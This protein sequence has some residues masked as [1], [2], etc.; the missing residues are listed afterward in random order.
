M[1]IGIVMKKI[2]IYIQ[3]IIFL[4]FAPHNLQSQDQTDQPVKVTPKQALDAKKEQF[5][6]VQQIASPLFDPVTSS[7][8]TKPNPFPTQS[9]NEDAVQN[10]FSAMGV[11]GEL[12]DHI[13]ICYFY[14]EFITKLELAAHTIALARTKNID[15]LTILESTSWQGLINKLG[16]WDAVVK[17]ID[18]SQ[19]PSQTDINTIRGT[20]Q[21]P[22]WKDVINTNFWKSINTTPDLIIKSNF[23]QNYCK[24]TVAQDFDKDAS[25]LGSIYNVETRIFMYIPNIDVAYYNEDFTALRLSSEYFRLTMVLTDAM[26]NRLIKQ[27]FDWK[28]FYDKTTNNIDLLKSYSAA[29]DFKNTT[30]YKLANLANQDFSKVVQ[31]AG[32]NEFPL[33]EIYGDNKPN[34]LAVE[35]ITCLAMI[36]NLQAQLLNLFNT[37]NLETTMKT[38]ADQTTKKPIPNILLYEADDHL[39]LEDLAMVEDAFAQ[40]AETPEEVL[41]ESDEP[42]VVQ[43]IGSWMSNNWHKV[44][45]RAKH[46]WSNVEQAGKATWKDIKNVGGDLKSLGEDALKAAEDEGGVLSQTMAAFGALVSVV[47]EGKDPKEAAKK[48]QKLWQ[49]AVKLQQKVAVD[50]QKANKDLQ[51]VMND[52]EVV[53]RDAS[54]IGAQAIGDVIGLVDKKLGEDVAGGLTAAAALL[55]DFYANLVDPVIAVVGGLVVLTADAAAVAANVVTK[56]IIDIA[57]GNFSQLGSDVLDGIETMVAD[58]AAT[59]WS[60]IS[61]IGK[62][63]LQQLSDAVKFIG[64]M[65]AFLTD[66]LV[67]TFAFATRTLA[68]LADSVGLPGEKFLE[69]MA[70]EAEAH[71]R[72]IAATITTVLLVVAVIATD[73]AAIPLLAMTV[74]P[75][76]FQIGGAFQQ[77]QQ[78]EQMKQEQKQFLDDYKKFVDNNE[79]VSTNAKN[80]WALELNKKYQAQITNQERELGFYQN[81][82]TSYFEGTQDQMSFYLGMNLAPQ[83]EQNKDYN[84]LRFADVGALYGF[85]TGDGKNTGVLNLNPSQGFPLY[86]DGRKL[87]S[88]EIAVYPALSMQLEDDKKLTS[89]TMHKFWFNQRETMPLDQETNMVEIRFQ[90]IY[91]LNMFNIGIYFGGEPVDVATIVKEK[92]A[93]IDAGHLAKILVFNKETKDA[94]V[95]LKVYEHEGQGWFSQQP[96]GPAFEIGTWYHM[97]MQLNDTNLQVSIWKE[98]DQEPSPQSYTVQK[99][100]QKT[101]GVISSGASIQ[102]EVITPKIPIN[103]ISALRPSLVQP[104]EQEREVQARQLLQIKEHPTVGSFKLDTTNRFQTLKGQ[105]I[106]KTQATGL[107]DEKNQMIDDYVV[108]GTKV[109][110]QANYLGTS[111]AKDVGQYQFKD[112]PDTIITSLING[113]VYNKQG[114][115]ENMVMANALDIFLQKHGPLSDELTK[116]LQTLSSAQQKAQAGPFNFGPIKLNAT[117]LDDIKQGI[118]IYQATSPEKKLQD[119][120]GNPVKDIQGNILFDYFMMKNSAGNFGGPYSDD[121]KT[122]RSL[123]TGFEYDR[124]ST[125]PNANTKDAPFPAG[126]QAPWIGI[127]LPVKLATLIDTAKNYYAQQKP[128][129]QST[130]G[131]S[132]QQ[133]GDNNVSNPTGPH[134]TQGSDKTNPLNTNPADQS[135]QERTQ[136]AGGD[137]FGG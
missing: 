105:F 3:I 71:R 86:N 81:F 97:K 40:K 41:K 35:E 104:T 116:T 20:I 31:M 89:E 92:K 135:L 59:M 82:L 117:S 24:F 88:Q 127:T 8:P 128:T 108:L 57:K 49:D 130:G 124:G 137:G 77:D 61:F 70:Q 56:S 67:D 78:Q 46:S 101:I 12:L 131:S 60:T 115:S 123:V 125:Q 47:T 72:T 62:Q 64:Y 74:G 98:G 10:A 126:S 14:V 87:F 103:A 85:A 76:L 73:G 38:F 23:W 107:K 1:P 52:T 110:Q 28:D 9:I 32:A 5:Q 17:Q 54:T 19:P 136:D 65:V 55:I 43:G 7:T 66:V 44:K 37:T 36:K 42:V 113:N 80:T 79:I 30:F 34:P 25:L 109:G 29:Q 53:A 50:I 111:P 129:Q 6:N 26:R 16:G 39:Y 93:N 132:V 133:T 69:T 45:N 68:A 102:Y 120:T 22:T 99:T 84:N 13:K 83:L 75:Q 106:Y 90:T 48:A 27:V 134:T 51:Q 94:P 2:G 63:F 15:F 114:L 18:Q 100:P 4:I 21:T 91:A 112:A 96:N 11:K 118:F 119:T 95:A 122:V 58:V 33:K 121:I